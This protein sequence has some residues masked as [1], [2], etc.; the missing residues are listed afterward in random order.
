MGFL[1]EKAGADGGDA[2]QEKK[3]CRDAGPPKSALR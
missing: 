3:K 1:P 2:A